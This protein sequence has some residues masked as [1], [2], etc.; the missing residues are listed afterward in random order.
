MTRHLLTAVRY[1]IPAALAVAGVAILASGG[2]AGLE[3]GAMFIGAGMSVLLLNVLYRMGAS[4][5]RDR[6]DED[7]ARRYF[8]AHGRWPDEER[9]PRPAPS[10]T[11]EPRSST[12]PHRRGPVDRHGRRVREPRAP[13]RSHSA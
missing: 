3:G 8:D 11:P 5:D 6:E 9:A 13:R 7:E 2:D 12:D 10:P 1:V 4:G